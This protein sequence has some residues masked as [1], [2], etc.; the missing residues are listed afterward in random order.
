MVCPRASIQGLSWTFKWGCTFQ[1][2]FYMANRIKAVFV[3]F[4]KLLVKMKLFLCGKFDFYRPL[5]SRVPF[6]IHMSQNDDRLCVIAEV[7]TNFPD[8]HMANRT[9]FIRLWYEAA[10]I[11]TSK[12][13]YLWSR[14]D[15]IKLWAKTLFGMAVSSSELIDII[16]CIKT[17]FWE[18]IFGVYFIYLDFLANIQI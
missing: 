2:G 1:W 7:P 5:H 13:L 15:A 6:R 4:P 16:Y 18:W 3:I 8:L 17:D 9:S 10:S 12:K 11:Q 14:Y